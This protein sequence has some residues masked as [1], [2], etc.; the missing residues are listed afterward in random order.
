MERTDNFK[1]TFFMCSFWL[2]KHTSVLPIQNIKLKEN[3]S[4]KGAKTEHNLSK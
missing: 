1:Y 4:G 2:W 3:G